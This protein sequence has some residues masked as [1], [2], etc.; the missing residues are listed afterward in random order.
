[1]CAYPSKMFDQIANLYSALQDD[2]NFDS[3]RKWKLQWAYRLRVLTGSLQ[4]SDFAY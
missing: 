3:L 4:G 2:W 1:M